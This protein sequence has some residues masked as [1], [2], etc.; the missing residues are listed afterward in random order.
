MPASVA[1]PAARSFS[2]PPPATFGF[3]SRI[4]ATT[5]RE[6]SADEQEISGLLAS[7]DRTYAARRW[8]LRTIVDRIGSGDAFAAALLHR[9]GAGADDPQALEFAVAAAAL[10]HSLPGDASLAK[11]EDINALLAN[12]GF[13]VRR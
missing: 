1:T 12:S 6:S 11:P 3:G 2:I 9:L 7:R 5:R 8:P 10:K 13:G 4:A